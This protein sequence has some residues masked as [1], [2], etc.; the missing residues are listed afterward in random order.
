MAVVTV[1][2][3][4]LAGCEAAL[5]LASRGVRV[6]LYEM[7]PAVMTSAHRTGDLAELVC[8]NSLKSDLLPSGQALLKEELRL[9]GCTLLQIAG[10]E[11]VPAGKA[12]AVDRGRFALAVTTR[13]QRHPLIELVREEATALDPGSL[14]V[15]ATGPLTSASMAAWLERTCGVAALHFYDAI[16]P[17]IDGESI[18][19]GQLFQGDRYDKGCGDHWNIPLDEKAYH[20]FVSA[21]RG[22]DTVDERSWER[23]ACF[24]GCLPIEE[25][26][27]RGEDA[28]AFGPFRPVGLQRP[29]LPRAAAVVQLRREDLAGACYNLV[30]CQTR[31]PVPE[32]QRVFRMLPGLGRARFLRFGQVHRNAY[33]D[34]PRV[35]TPDLALRAAPACRVAGQL[36]GTE[37]YVESIGMGL[38]AAIFTLGELAGRAV[39]VP[40]AETML[41]ALCR[42][43]TMAGEA[44][45]PMNAHFGLLP[46][47][48]P[49]VRGR[50]A[51]RAWMCERSLA[52][53]AAWRRDAVDP[54][55]ADSQP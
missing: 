27:R 39:S 48:P 41:G 35:L 43:V 8:S 26:A 16:S 13:I 40:P 47:A 2:G 46:D 45:Q 42:Y 53:L 14:T 37:G 51:R 10:A 19:F 50:P 18:D 52:A 5:Y 3:G 38:L 29:G 36:S 1:I 28:L 20:D 17:I 23:I 22:A 11:R 7:R 15:L 33:L 12:L 25:I 30:G 32:Q 4:G 21:L 24:E 49:S 34:A 6:R 31:M 54:L 9:M 44:F 55:A